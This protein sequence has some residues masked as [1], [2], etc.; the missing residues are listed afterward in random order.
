[1]TETPQQQRPGA[2]TAY[3]PAPGID[4]EHLRDYQQLRRS[5]TDRK[6]AGVAGGLGR[7]L[8][9]DP[10]II[11]VTF[12]VLT[13]FGGAGALLYG[14]AWLIVPVDGRNDAP[15]DTNAR[16]RSTLLIIAGAFAALAVVANSWGGVGVPLPLA[17]LAILVAALVMSRDK[18]GSTPA[19]QAGGP[20]QQAVP[21]GAVPTTTAPLTTDTGTTLIP[22]PIG[23]GTPPPAPPWMSSTQPT[24]QQ[25]TYQQPAYQPPPKTG[26]KLFGP[27]LALVAIGLG[28]LGTFDS[29]GYDVPVAAYPALA[30]ALI[31]AMLVVGA[32]VGRAGGLIFLGTVS[33]IVLAVTSI[34]GTN[35]GRGG[36]VTYRP[37]DASAVRERYSMGAGRLTLDLRGV[38]DVGGLDGQGITVRGRVGELVVL[39]PDDLRAEVLADVRLGDVS[40]GGQTENGPQVRVTR[41]VGSTD[42]TDPQVDLDLG[43]IVGNIE[44]RES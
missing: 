30:L 36:E 9:I 37:S 18:R 10:T 14:L 15:I 25:P 34:V 11:R 5:V 24:Y 27:T 41:Q 38:T 33:A 6:L 7:H 12:V 32:W 35:P 13:L 40:I 29:L 26:T 2:D 42:G 20:A 23:G 44:V 22:P 39:L 3:G 4:R 17:I 21:G 1:M 16:T 8:N 31:G 43:L 19:A 28:T